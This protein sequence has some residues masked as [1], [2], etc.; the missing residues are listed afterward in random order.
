M[1]GITSVAKEKTFENVNDLRKMVNDVK[2]EATVMLATVRPQKPGMPIP[3]A[4]AGI[5]DP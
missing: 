2:K 5:A 4:V 1:H 3:N